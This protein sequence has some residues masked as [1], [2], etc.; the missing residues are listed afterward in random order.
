MVVAPASILTGRVLSASGKTPLGRIAVTLIPTDPSR[1]SAF[2]RPNGASNDQG[3]F[4]V[5]GAP[6]EYF[7]ILWARGEPVPPHDADSIKKLLPNAV[8]VTLGPEERK[9]IELIK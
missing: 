1:G 3:N 4:L 9:S 2:A 8:R 7:V 6:G 5:S